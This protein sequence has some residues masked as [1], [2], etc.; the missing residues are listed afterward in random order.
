MCFITLEDA[1]GTANLVIW[2][3]VF[4]AFRKAINSARV[5]EV[6]GQIH[7]CDR[8]IQLVAAHA[9]DRNA[10]LGDYLARGRPRP[11]CAPTN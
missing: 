7:C 5:I 4:E 2:P 6:N 10:V 8:M 3:K 9:A 1:T 11:Y